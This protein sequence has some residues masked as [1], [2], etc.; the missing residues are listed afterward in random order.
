MRKRSLIWYQILFAFFLTA[1]VSLAQAT[2]YVASMGSD[3][4]DGRFPS[5]PFKSLDRVNKIQLQPG[6]A[7]LFRRGDTFRGTLLVRQSGAAGKSIR[8][9][10]YGSGAKPVLAGS[11]P[12]RNWTQAGTNIWQASCSNCGSDLTGLYRNGLAQPLG[13]YPNP[14]ALN[15]GSLTVQTHVGTT[16]LTSQQALTRDWTGGEVVARPTYWIIDRAPITRQSG[17]T[18]TLANTSHYTL[19][20]GWGFFIQKHPATLDRTG[21]WYY[22]PATR[23]IQIYHDQ[24]DPN[25]QFITAGVTDKVI[26]IAD[27]AFISIQ[28]LSVVQARLAN[29]HALN[30][31]NLVLSNDDFTDSGEDGVLI[32]GTGTNL[33]IEKNTIANSNNNGVYIDAYQQVTFRQNFI[34]R[35]G[36]MPGRGRN[37]DGQLNAFQSFAT[38]NS[39]I[40][41]NVI[42]SVGYIGI[43]VQ[44]NATVRQNLITNFCM[45]KSDGGGIYLWNGARQ[46]MDSIRIESN[47]IRNGIGTPGSLSDNTFSGAHGIFLDD[48][49][50][51]VDLTNNTVT[52]C[53]GM[54]I[55]LHAV[56]GVS[57]TGNTCFN[58]SVAQLILYNYE[59]QCL[60]RNNMLQQNSL[61]A[62]TATQGVAGYIS[63]LD[64]L[65]SFGLMT[66]NYYARPFNDLSTIRAVYNR[67]VVGD[68]N[69]AQWQSQFGHDRTS[70]SSPVTYKEYVVKSR[71]TAN[72]FS[73]SLSGN[74][75]GWETWSPY[76]NGQAI[77]NAGGQSTGDGLTITFPKSSGKTD[78]YVQAY[79]EIKAVVKS[80]SYLVSF[81]VAAPAAKKI[82]VFIRQQNAP[83]QDLT[84]RYEFM[85]GPARRRYEFALT[86]SVSEADALLTFQLGEDDQS[87]RLDNIQLQEATIEIVNPDDFIRLVYNPTTKDSTVVLPHPSRDVKNHYYDRRVVLKPFTSVVLLSDSLPP[88]DVRLSLAIDR[89]SLRIGESTSIS[90]TLRSPSGDRT[91]PNQVQWS[92]QLPASLTLV[93]N[94]TLSGHDGLL[95]GRVQRLITDTTFV[96]RVRATAVGRY[97]LAAQ[98]TATTHA[99]PTSTPNSGTNDGEDDQALVTLLVNEDVLGKTAPGLVTE[100]GP[101]GS[102]IDESLI[103]PNPS[104]DEFTFVAEDDVVRMQMVDLLGRE[105][106]SLGPVRRGQLIRFG[107][108]LPNAPYLLYIHYKTGEQRVVR[109]IKQNL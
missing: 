96:F 31:S 90:L 25:E 44:R 42:D 9:D 69:L 56:S 26:D 19:A 72:R 100:I 70:R 75:D 37:G 99:D 36:L 13:R 59:Q 82:V 6:D 28:N 104:P 101:A 39:R 41:N 15:R 18:L 88:V 10:G 5:S 46:S 14:D 91:L 47:I 33:L 109:L 106:F 8:F 16:Q 73:G 67:T 87:V 66:H 95:T 32:Q 38:Q 85:A 81:D 68:L 102:R 55:Y 77:W 20:D 107:R 60:P 21:E 71:S 50:E 12:V 64:D 78:S 63:G 57:L 22:N 61:I 11:V 40:E 86:V 27:A 97:V 74:S 103:Y 76:N 94:R 45:T 17:N 84:R 80:K 83:Y 43:S 52:D 3:T 58:N 92:C 65:S 79:K 51:G 89:D 7:V 62:K 35:I 30:V 34:R 98:V 23:V 2:Y 108:S 1:S 24:G 48:C 93:G 29:L 105:R 53:Q 4:N 54:G 49:V